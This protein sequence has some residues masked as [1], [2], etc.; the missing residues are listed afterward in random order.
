MFVRQ[1]IMHQTTYLVLHRMTPGSISEYNSWDVSAYTHG[2]VGYSH[3]PHQSSTSGSS[4]HLCPSETFSHKTEHRLPTAWI[5]SQTN[6]L[7]RKRWTGDSI[8]HLRFAPERTR[9][10]L[11]YR[12]EGKSTFVCCLSETRLGGNVPR[13]KSKGW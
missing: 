1:D 11:Y 10:A 5:R 8:L 3:S 12:A 4:A 6:W 9:T 2:S 13:Y 7:R